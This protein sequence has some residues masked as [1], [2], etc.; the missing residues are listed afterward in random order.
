VTKDPIVQYTRTATLVAFFKVLAKSNRLK[1][2]GL[3]A[4]Q[5]YTVEHLAALLGVG[6]PTVSHHLRKFAGAVWSG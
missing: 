4:Q 3:L 1:I 2:I 6:S 5:P